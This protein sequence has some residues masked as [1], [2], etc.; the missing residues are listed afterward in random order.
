MLR[1]RSRGKYTPSLPPPRELILAVYPPRGRLRSMY[2]LTTLAPSAS[3]NSRPQLLQ[4]NPV[5]FP[6]TILSPFC[7]QSTVRGCASTK[8]PFLQTGQVSPS[9]SLRGVFGLLFSSLFLIC[10]SRS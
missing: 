9:I 4:R 2:R 3:R 1:R 10:S 5:R 6:T 7:A 8:T